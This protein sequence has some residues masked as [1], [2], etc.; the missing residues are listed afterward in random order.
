M[1]R[2]DEQDFTDDL[3]IAIIA[4][5]GRF[6]QA[7]DTNQFWQNLKDGV[8]SISF[9]SDL[10]VLESG[11][12]TELLNNPNYVKA[13]AVLSDVD[14]FDANFFSYSPKEAEEMD[15]QQRLFLE[16]SWETIEKGGYNPET[17]QGLIGVYAGVGMNDYLLKNLY[18]NSEISS[19]VNSYQLM[20]ASDKDYLATRVA[21]KLNLR[22]PAVNVQTACST[23]LVAVHLACQSLLNGECDMALAGGASI[24][25]PQKSGYL[26]QEGMIA[27]PDGHCRTFDA[28]AKGTNGGDGVGIVLL[29][30]LNNAIADGDE[31]H[32][33]IKGSAINNDGSLKVG[34]T[35]PSMEG[36]AEVISEAQ[37]IAGVDAETIS[38][39]EAH[40]TG[41][42]LG[43][44]VEIAALTKAFRY[45]TEK[46]GFCAIGA[47]KSN[48]GHLDAAAGVA[49]LIKTVLA[50]KHK[51]LPPTLHFEKPNP[52]INFVD[53]PFYVNAT[54]SEWKSNGT[55]RRAGVSAFGIG[56]TNAHVILEEAPERIKKGNSPERPVNLLSLSAK[57]PEAL[58]Q[59]VARYQNY[60][61]THQELE[62][63]DICYTANTGRKHFN[64]RL[65]IIA[66]NQQELLEKLKSYQEEEQVR[67]LFY[68][69]SPANK[70]AQV[71]FLFTGQGSQ[72]LGMGKQLY[73]TQPVF[74]Q[75][76]EECSQILETELEKSIIEVIYPENPESK[77]A[78]NILEQTN[79]T[80]PTLFAIEYALFKLWESWG[81]RPD[82]VMGHSV[83]EYVAAT[84]AGVLSL[85]DGLKLIA[86]RGRL[87]QKLPTVGQMVS[88]MASESQLY[89]LIT[90]YL[91]KVAIA[92][93]NG[94]E[95]TV[96]SGE[97]EA[98]EEIVKKAESK[99][100]K[101]KKL[102]VSHAFHSPLMKPMLAEFAAVAEEI[103][104]NQPRI[105]LI[106]NVTG[107]E[108]KEEI[109]T[110]KYWVNHVCQ[111]VKFY[112]S[113]KTLHE[114]GYEL[115]LEIGPKPILLGMGRQCLPEEVG[116]WLPS[117]RPTLSEWEQMLS[118]LG[119]LYI[120][121]A[122]VNWLGV[123]QGYARQKVVLPTYPFER[124]RHWIEPKKKHQ[125]Q[126]K[127]NN[128]LN[129]LLGKRFDCAGQ[130][131]Q[132]Q[133]ES[134]IAAF[135][136]AYLAEHL[137][138]GTVIVPATVYLEMAL[139]A[140][141]YLW[142]SPDLV[143]ENIVV[144]KAL[145]LSQGEVKTIQT[146]LTPLE[147]G[148]YKF[149]I[150]TKKQLENQ[151]MPLWTCH[152]QGRIKLA[153]ADIHSKNVDL[154]QYKTECIQPIDVKEYYQHIR[155][156]GLDLGN[157]FQGIQK[158]WIGSNKSLGK[159]ELSEELLGEF[160]YL[161]HPALFDAALQSIH[162]KNFT[163]HQNKDRLYLPLE[164]ERLRFYRRLGKSAWAIG[165]FE[166]N[167]GLIVADEQGTVIAQLD[168]FRM[169]PA[170]RKALLRSIQSDI[171]DWFYKIDWQVHP[172]ES[173]KLT[174]ETPIGN[175]LVF[176]PTQK[177]AEEIGKDLEKNGHQC[178]WVSP[179]KEYECLN[180][181]HYQINPS[182]AEEFERLI[183][184]N[185]ELKGI[186]HLWGLNE[187]NELLNLE[188]LQKAQELG[189]CTLLHLVKA[190][191]KSGLSHLPPIWSITQGTQS[192]LGEI[193]VVQPEQGSL[194]GLGQVIGLEHPE[195]ASRRVDLDP[196]SSVSEVIPTLVE[197]ILSTNGED[198]IAYRQ[199][200]RYVP[201]LRRQLQQNLG[202][203]SQLSIETEASY[204][205]TGGLGALG[206]EVAQWLVNQGAKYLVLTGRNGPSETASQTIEKLEKT[207]CNISILLG[208]ISS[209]QDVNHI[210]DQ[211]Q[212][213]LPPLKGVVHAAGV[214]D[215]G[216]IQQMNW[217]RFTKVMAPKLEG[218]WH[219]HKLT[220]NMPLDFFVC[221]SSIASLIGSPGQGNYAAANSFMDAIVHYRRGMGLSGLSINWGPWGEI[222]MAARLAGQ[223]QNQIQAMGLNFINPNEGM[224]ALRGLLLNPEAQ[225]GVLPV[226]WF[227]FFRQSPKMKVPFLEEF[228]SREK[229]K[230]Q[231][232]AFIEQLEATPVGK[233]KDLLIA[234]I[235]SLIASFLHIKDKQQI[236][237]RQ[238]FFDLG[239]DS[240][241]AI[242]FKNILE[243]SLEISVSSTLLFDYAT[244][245]SLVDYLMNEALSLEFEDSN[246]NSELENNVDRF[247]EGLE[248]LS[249]AEIA[250]LLA[251]EIS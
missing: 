171:S 89:Q 153:E 201:R 181:Q 81:I 170:T 186:L 95:S 57:T 67:E 30:R 70:I 246:E 124:Q 31:I 143:L 83:G 135:D 224:Q 25:L 226:N 9:F 119:Q 202:E 21:Y 174:T 32:A 46:K 8:E 37:A 129:P 225:V 85:E 19:T 51:L 147:G 106:S 177:L 117:L 232:A 22:G 111:P 235:R 80:Q 39:I 203:D 36:Q 198:Q 105:T 160:D 72:Y 118:S 217:E 74:R 100:I 180:F 79:Y 205:I 244:L 23:S 60:I 149:Q 114:E 243:S 176:A 157:S 194:W 7:E 17:Y 1:E 183:E 68:G 148:S 234:E 28:K 167:G 200:V 191:I 26:Y 98:I 93:I 172:I 208:D 236:Q 24:H 248:D 223:N 187:T 218:S 168:G 11:V 125:A 84:V 133:F 123:E 5:G 210:F 221:F 247:D 50:L 197:E 77:E 163:D 49:G 16:C 211:I 250:E 185:H 2:Q 12:K 122:K 44:P 15:P 40:G 108:V 219:L 120:Q 78:A 227:E 55:P 146:I 3:G 231:K 140:G 90:P 99:G 240:L 94:P 13:S 38:Y 169:V 101:S 136:P 86:A 237:P 6:P 209:E 88:L 238:S 132:I 179:G 175:W 242:E 92:A 112:E 220:Q 47:L 139:S 52:K 165:S 192:V 27:S 97:S 65:A 138:F 155:Q 126:R 212:E 152:V 188:K 102:Q 204:L 182:V 82:V 18:P 222:G 159:V 107:K 230:T 110:A 103:T 189:C 214:L 206:L 190:L 128:T 73:E 56:G 184:E 241:M 239:L 64:H 45:S 115:F 131:E 215:D 151:L 71:A 53:S 116:V 33:I 10:E 233:R 66:E 161:L 199:G 150:L 207:G 59:L 109:A 63:A 58:T 61:E 104:Y 245:E 127:E 54:L 43:D 62:I 76:L 14:M 48:I 4:I 121:G 166:E 173:T 96:I 87:M 178:I 142:N 137:A 113:M 196:K 158:L 154:E 35:A 41:T 193:D 134:Q 249:E 42:E 20:L 34:Y 144:Q 141:Y 229:V 195:L 29:K 156:L 228:I 130:P 164:I 213:S 69:E 162:A 91:E 251:K 75:A 216:V 145:I